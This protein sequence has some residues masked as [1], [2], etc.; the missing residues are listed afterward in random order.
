[1]FQLDPDE[2]DDEVFG[3]VQIKENLRFTSVSAKQTND[4]NKQFTGVVIRNI[5]LELQDEEIMEFLVSNGV[6]ANHNCVRISNGRKNK[7][8]EIGELNDNVC[9][10]VI[11]N[12]HQEVNFNRKI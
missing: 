2:V 1:M 3:D 10:E 5:P 6:P 9:E 4:G 7:I 11:N 8:V 12:I